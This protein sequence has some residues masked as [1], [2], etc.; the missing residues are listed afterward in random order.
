MPQVFDSG[1]L[2]GFGA[3]T[4]GNML[5]QL[6]GANNEHIECILDNNAKKIGTMTTGSLIP[7]VSETDNINRLPQNIIIL[8]YYYAHLFTKTIRRAL[9]PGNKCNLI[10]PLPYPK[11][12]TIQ[13]R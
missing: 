8:P 7:I 1:P 13:G 12:V 11:L 5:L 10:I 6:I 4:K 9:T 2:W 3:S